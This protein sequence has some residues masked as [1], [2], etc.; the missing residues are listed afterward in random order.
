MKLGYHD[1]NSLARQRVAHEDDRTGWIVT[2]A[3]DAMAA[4]GRCADGHVELLAD[5]HR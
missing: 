2:G 3:G 1:T 5:G 4:V